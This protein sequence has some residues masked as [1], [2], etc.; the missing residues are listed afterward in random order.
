MEWLTILRKKIFFRSYLLDSYCQFLTKNTERKT[1]SEMLLLWL[2]AL[3][4]VWCSS[5]FYC[6]VRKEISF[7]QINTAIVFYYFQQGLYIIV[8]HL[9]GSFSCN[10]TFIILQSLFFMLKSHH[11]KASPTRKSR[12]VTDAALELFYECNGEFLMKFS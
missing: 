3:P 10:F 8:C 12:V 2:S 6:N 1:W 5:L 9:L 4:L 11:N 7:L